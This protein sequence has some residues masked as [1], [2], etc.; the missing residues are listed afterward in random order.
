MWALRGPTASRP[1]AAAEPR[2]NAAEARRQAPPDE[3]QAIRRRED[4]KLLP[5]LIG[6]V[7]LTALV[8]FG[9]GLIFGVASVIAMM[10]IAEGASLEAQ[11]QTALFR[12][13]VLIGRPPA[14][15]PP[16]AARCAQ[17]PALSRPLPVGNGATLLARR[18]D[19]RRAE[20]N[21]AAATASPR[22]C[23][24]NWTQVPWLRF[25]AA[26]RKTPGPVNSVTVAIFALWEPAKLSIRLPST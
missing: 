12:L 21:L 22:I 26:P 10:A 17:P 8:M 14:D 4:P 16:D 5:L 15:I 6:V 24:S 20:R 19:I 23:R 7:V 1:S 13:A 25:P 9:I 2:A 11:R 18:P 3:G